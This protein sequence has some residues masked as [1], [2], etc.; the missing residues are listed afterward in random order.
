MTE[1]IGRNAVRL[2]LPSHFK[3]H[4]VV[5]VAHTTPFMEQPN[6]IG[7]QIEQRPLPIPTIE[8][9][10]HTVEAILQHRKRGKGYQFLTLM[11]GA[12][13]HDA[14]W[15]PTRDFVDEDGTVTGIW[16]DY[17]K[18]HGILPQYH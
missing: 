4:P 11:K 18:Q 17:I 9:E 5:H 3:I 2:E 13:R 8:G 12:P 15:Q 10:E 16:Y 1:L 14:E 7:I 6:D